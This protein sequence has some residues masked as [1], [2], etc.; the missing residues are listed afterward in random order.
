MLQLR[1]AAT[2]VSLAVAAVVGSGRFTE[3]N[4]CNALSPQETARLEQMET[5]IMK[6]TDEQLVE[7]YTSAVRNLDR[8]IAA[9]ESQLTEAEQVLSRKIDEIRASKSKFMDPHSLALDK[10]RRIREVYTE[11]SFHGTQQRIDKELSALRADRRMAKAELKDATRRVADANAA[12]AEA[13]RAARYKDLQTHLEAVGT[14][15]RKIE[16]IHKE[17]D[18]LYA[19]T[20]ALQNRDL[21]LA[22]N[23]EASADYYKDKQGSLDKVKAWTA[24]ATTLRE[25]M[26]ARLRSYN[27][28]LSDLKAKKSAERQA[29]E[30]LVDAREREVSR[31]LNARVDMTG[32]IAEFV[33][34]K[35]DEAVFTYTKLIESAERNE[36]RADQIRN[37][38]SNRL[39]QSMGSDVRDADKTT[40]AQLEA[41]AAYDRKMAAQI[42]KKYDARNNPIV[43]EAIKR[44]AGARADREAT[45]ARNLDKARRKFMRPLANS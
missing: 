26:R 19:S 8:K 11:S 45:L 25:Q 29:L 6:L 42:E 27:A 22:K 5:A 3:G 38:P 14:H 16:Q 13:A 20:K 23:A 10:R 15:R 37:S 21:E 44:F 18:D 32:E 41:A 33:K 39:R 30:D 35:N 2:L 36:A 34:Q 4:K 7:A 12:T 1:L 43:H 28:T 31:R 17:T 9:L 40:M 24:E